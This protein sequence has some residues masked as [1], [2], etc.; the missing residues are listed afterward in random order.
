VGGGAEGDGGMPKLPIGG[1]EFGGG[2]LE[3]GGGSDTTQSTHATPMIQFDETELG[4][5]VGWTT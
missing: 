3:T 4:Q 5:R 2:G 1:E